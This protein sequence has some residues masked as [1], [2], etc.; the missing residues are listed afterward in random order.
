MIN[1]R[2]GGVRLSEAHNPTII[3]LQNRRTGDGGQWSNVDQ[4]R[5]TKYNNKNI[6]SRGEKPPLRINSR[7]QS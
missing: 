2:Y 1:D 6:P 5:T 4:N 3:A 7:S